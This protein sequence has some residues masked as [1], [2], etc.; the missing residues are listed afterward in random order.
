MKCGASHPA[1]PWE[2]AFSRKKEGGEVLFPILEFF[3]LSRTQKIPGKATALVV[4][5]G[6][7]S[8]VE[9]ESWAQPF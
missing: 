4:G 2:V 8:R 9:G 5:W 3:E 7:E 1:D 6:V